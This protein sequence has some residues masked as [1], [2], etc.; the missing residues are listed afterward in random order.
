MARRQRRRLYLVSTSP[1]RAEI[2]RRFGYAFETIPPRSEAVEIQH[3]N[4]TI[5]AALEKLPHQ[6]GPGVYLAADTMV[7]LG[8]EPLGKPRNLE[9]ARAFLQRLSDREHRVVTGYAIAAEP[10]GRIITGTVITEVYF[11]PLGA[12]EINL[13]LRHGAPLDKAGAYGIQG[14]AGL[15]IRYLKGSYFN[16]VGLPIETLYPLLKSLGIVPTRRPKV[17]EAPPARSRPG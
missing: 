15:F 13:L 8:T 3:P 17:S 7:F 6:R 12:E 5:Q 11:G 10:E 16:V 4:H 2:L 9:E 14:M 1:R